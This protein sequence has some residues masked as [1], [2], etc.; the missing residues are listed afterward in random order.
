MC[1]HQVSVTFSMST[2]ELE[3]LKAQNVGEF[4]CA[5]FILSIRA[6]LSFFDTSTKTEIMEIAELFIVQFLCDNANW[7][8]GE[9]QQD[10]IAIYADSDGANFIR[11]AGDGD[12]VYFTQLDGG[13]TFSVGLKCYV[14]LLL[15]LTIDLERYL[16]LEFP[17]LRSN[18]DMEKL[19]KE[20]Q[21]G[22]KA[23]KLNL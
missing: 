23:F 22:L 20:I 18:D 8:I 4:D 21:Q 5:S 10:E 7:I 6:T 15:A 17:Q 1:S 9:I 16:K 12:K 2:G 3:Q 11:I 19:F 13:Q 14:A